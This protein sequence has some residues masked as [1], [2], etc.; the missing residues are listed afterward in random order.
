MT[1]FQEGPP[2]VVDLAWCRADLGSDEDAPDGAGADSV[3]EAA[4][5]ALHAATPPAGIFAGQPEDKVAYVVADPWTS[6]PVGPIR[7]SAG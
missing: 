2:A 1:R 5:F 7:F 6:G 4:Q 3:A